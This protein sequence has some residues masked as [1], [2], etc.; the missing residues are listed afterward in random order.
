MAGSRVK[1]MNFA[2]N[3]MENYNTGIRFGEIYK[4]MANNFPQM[5]QGSLYGFIRDLYKSHSD[6]IDKPAR[7]LYILK[8]FNQNV[9]P[10][11]TTNPTNPTKP[12]IREEDFYKPFADYLEN[13]LDECTTAI[14]LGGNILGDKWGTPDVVG[15]I[16]PSMSD[17]IKE[18]E[19]IT[20]E[21]KTDTSALITAFGQACA[22]KLF[23]H[24]VYLVIPEQSSKAD[25]DRL[26]SLCCLFGI[27]LIT[28]NNMDPNN[29]NF[30]I[31]NRAQKAIPDTFY[32]NTKIKIIADKLQI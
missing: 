10:N 1:E 24:R 4:L 19:I 5:T 28:L 9:S 18:I 32:L 27:G 7:G 29:P 26:D 2:L 31:K 8:K 16:K 6:K 13:D 11:V 30:Q 21:I 25:I 22:Y 20:A 15:V 3:E 17:I 14:S 23:S 12:S